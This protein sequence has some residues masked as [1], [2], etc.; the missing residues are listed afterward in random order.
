PTK[1]GPAAGARWQPADSLAYNERVRFCG[2]RPFFVRSSP[3]RDRIMSR[4]WPVES[5]GQSIRRRW[6]AFRHGEYDPETLPSIPSWGLSVVL[7]ALLLLILA[8]LIRWSHRPPAPEASFDGAIV[9]T[10]L[11]EVM[12]LVDAKQAGD[13]FTLTNSP[14]PPSLGLDSDPQLKLV[15]QPEIRSLTQFTPALAGPTPLLDA[16]NT[17][18]VGMKFPELST[19]VT[20]PFSGRQGLTRAKLVRRE[21][22]TA[23]SEKSV[24]DGIDWIVRHQRP[25]GSWSL[26]YH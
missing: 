23:L 21:G 11:G 24:E 20:A 3:E 13:P 16:K 10:Q 18:M 25:D 8:V 17:T 6:N 22:G 19:R 7:H 14:D 15:G 2:R 5:L 26:N 1:F 12:S 4:A 9:D